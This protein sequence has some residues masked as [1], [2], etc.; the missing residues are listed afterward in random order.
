MTEKL[1]EEQKQEA[2]KRIKDLTKK[3]NLNSNMLEHFQN[4]LT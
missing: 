3:L 1:R 2:L 4:D